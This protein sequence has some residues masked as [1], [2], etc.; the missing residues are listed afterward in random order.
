MAIYSIVFL[1]HDGRA[2]YPR[3]VPRS[4]WAINLPDSF[5]PAS[6][7]FLRD[8]Y[9]HASQGIKDLWDTGDYAC[10]ILQADI[11]YRFP[12]FPYEIQAFDVAACKFLIDPD[13][14]AAF[15][16][17]IMNTAARELV[18]PNIAAAQADFN[19]RFP[20]APP[21]DSTDQT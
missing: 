4:A 1:G 21:A 11:P 2:G 8:I 16:T 7:D 12:S 15:L 5:D 18:M 10:G 17:R 6:Y 14:G 20:P 19:S 9:P 3:S 13:K